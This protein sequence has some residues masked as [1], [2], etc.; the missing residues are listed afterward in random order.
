VL[1]RSLILLDT[2]ALLTGKTSDWQEFTKLGECYVPELVLEQMNYMC[3]RA[4]EPEVES[5]AREFGRFY[6]DS[7]WK[8]T[9]MKADHPS[10]KPSPG[11]T[12]S[13]RARLVLDGLGCAYGLALRYPDRLVVLVSGDQAMLQQAFNLET[14]NLCGI[15]VPALMQ[16]VR[17]ARRPPVVTQ[18][19]QQMR[20]GADG[21][22][23]GTRPTSGKRRGTAPLPSASAQRRLSGRSLSELFSTLVSLAM[24]ILIIGVI[25]RFVSPTSFNQFWQ[26]LPV[27]GKPAGSQR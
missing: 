20:P 18:H 16:W 11:H 17:S 2:T 24:F 13:K 8:K 25:W 14:K 15:P 21:D 4:S 27:V 6:P 1:F 3:D 26:N 23:H 5:V 9:S 12:L 22:A 10:L 19:L 7:G